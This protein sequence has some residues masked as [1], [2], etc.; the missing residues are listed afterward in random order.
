MRRHIRYLVML[1]IALLTL[2]TAACGSSASG[3]SG[4]N[5]GKPTLTITSPAQRATVQVPFTVSFNSSE[6]LGP[7]E[8]GLDHVHL[9]LDGKTSDY[10]VV[11]GTSF[12][13]KNLSPGEHTVQVTLQHADHSSA[14]ASAQVTVMVGGGGSG[15]T[16]SSSPSSSGG[17]DY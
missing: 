17:Y 3:N 11:P 9:F 4:G 13:I 7:P 12:E 14:G 8:S 2:V 1:G 16:P 10:T 5:S 6:K 15:G